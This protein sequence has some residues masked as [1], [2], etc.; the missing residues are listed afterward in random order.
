MG[1]WRRL[2]AGLTGLVLLATGTLAGCDWA[3]DTRFVHPVFE[4]I[5]ATR[6]VLY[7]TA[8]GHDGQPVE[9]RLNIYQ[10]RGDARDE[11]PVMMWMF[12]GA[13]QWGDRNQLALYAEDSAR[14]G[15]VGVTID[16]RVRPEGGPLLEVARD[17]YDD[18][19][20]A[21]AWLKD[22]AGEYRLDPDAIVAGG[23]SAGAV[24]AMNLLYTRDWGLDASPIAGGVSISGTSFAPPH[25]GDHAPRHGRHH[26]PLR[27][28]PADLRQ[29]HRGRQRV[30]VAGVPGRRP[31]HRD[32]ERGRDHG[33]HRRP[34][35]RAGALAARLPPRAGP[36]V[37]ACS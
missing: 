15:Y 32:L 22:H 29:R 16:Y 20:A 14:R 30:R 24:N 10:P 37:S 33:D 7:R 2:A 36:P 4:E 12:G 21:V 28:R 11:R 3:E 1:V 19:V 5:E 13:W 9:L 8:T 34:D 26:R 23:V 27:R 17:A 6:D 35:L 18:A 25:A 31:L